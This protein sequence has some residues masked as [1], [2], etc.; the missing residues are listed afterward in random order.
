MERR[1]IDRLQTHDG[2]IGDARVIG[3]HGEGKA[4]TMGLRCLVD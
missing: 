1:Q 3:M 2:K 4:G